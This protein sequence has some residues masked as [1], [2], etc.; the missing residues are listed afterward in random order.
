MDLLVDLFGKK[1]K[2][3]FRLL[4]LEPGRSTDVDRRLCLLYARD[5][6]QGPLSCQDQWWK[7][8]PS[9]SLS[10]FAATPAPNIFTRASIYLSARRR[11]LMRYRISF[12][13]SLEDLFV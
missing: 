1:K 8:P 3:K 9:C 7:M 6:Y 13:L 11:F 12:S 4:F 10:T 5:R 2:K